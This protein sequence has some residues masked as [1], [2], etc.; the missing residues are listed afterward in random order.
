MKHAIL[1]PAPAVFGHM[2]V[3]GRPLFRCGSDK[4]TKPDFTHN[5]FLLM[6]AA[7]SGCN[8]YWFSHGSPPYFMTIVVWSSSITVQTAKRVY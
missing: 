7:I 4:F 6:L 2:P 8:G 3:T 1:S 5:S